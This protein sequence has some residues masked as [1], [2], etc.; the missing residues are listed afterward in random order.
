VRTIVAFPAA[1]AL[2]AVPAA[3]SPAW[4]EIYPMP[5][6]VRWE[7]GPFCP[8]DD[9]HLHGEHTTGLRGWVCP[10]CGAWWDLRGQ[11][12]VWLAAPADG[13]EVQ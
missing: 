2:T 11:C 1:A 4:R 9:T 13:G 12:G 8:I 3:G 5:R 7:V 6:D 10:T